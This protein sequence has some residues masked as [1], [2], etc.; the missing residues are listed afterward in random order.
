VKGTRP[1]RAGFTLLELVIS[2]AVV[3]ALLVI[4]VPA[5]STARKSSYRALCAGN[6]RLIGQAWSMYLDANDGRFPTIHDLPGWKYGGVRYSRV[7]QTTAWLDH[8]LPL[9]RYLPVHRLDAPAEALFHCPA[10][11]GITGETG[12][13]GT[14]DRTAYEAFGT[15]YR[16]NAALLAPPTAAGAGSGHGLHRNEITTA[17]SRLVVMGDPVWYEVLESTGRVAAWHGKLDAGNLLFLDGSVRFVPVEP[18][19]QVGAAVFDPLEP[20]LAF[21]LHRK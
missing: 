3:C 11:R 18:R 13:V 12:G 9:N 15:S 20:G 5:L 2:L 8:N 19:P 21:P 16:A 14:G 4:L 1:L 7:D 6:Q 10:D 17:A